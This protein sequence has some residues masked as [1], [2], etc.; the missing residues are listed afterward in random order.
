MNDPY[1]SIL[2]AQ[3]MNASAREIER[4]EARLA[5]LNKKLDEVKKLPDIWRQLNANIPPNMMA[6]IHEAADELEASLKKENN[7][8]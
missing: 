7:D 1:R 2:D 4:L 5:E 6:S 3:M 8:E